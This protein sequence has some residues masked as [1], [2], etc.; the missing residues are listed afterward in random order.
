VPA[1]LPACLPACE[2]MSGAG[3]KSSVKTINIIP[4]AQSYETKITLTPRQNFF[5]ILRRI[6]I[7]IVYHIWY[8]I[9]E[10]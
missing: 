7:C 5:K 2:I 1:C 9:R 4:S 6:F 8:D 3:F 10:S